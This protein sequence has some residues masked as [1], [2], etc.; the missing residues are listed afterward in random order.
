MSVRE[1]HQIT[2]NKILRRL[3]QS[4]VLEMMNK[5]HEELK[6]RLESMGC[7]KTVFERV[8]EGRRPRGRSRLRWLDNFR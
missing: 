7:T 1:G 2:N 4:G 3:E 6:E 5:R 8:V